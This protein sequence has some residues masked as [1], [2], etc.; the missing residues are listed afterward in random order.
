MGLDERI[1]MIIFEL[2]LTTFKMSVIFRGG[3]DSSDNWLEPKIK[4]PSANL[5]GPNL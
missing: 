2:I 4:P 3:L 5:A 1:E